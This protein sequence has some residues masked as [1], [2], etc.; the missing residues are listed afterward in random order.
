MG[1]RTQN[2]MQSVDMSVIR[3]LLIIKVPLDPG[4]LPGAAATF[5]DPTSVQ[6]GSHNGQEHAFMAETASSDRSPSPEDYV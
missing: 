2:L 4:V 5:L 3:E 1:G 6:N